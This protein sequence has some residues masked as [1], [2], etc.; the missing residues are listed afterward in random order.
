[1]NKYSQLA[2]HCC[3]LFSC[4]TKIAEIIES[5]REREALISQMEQVGGGSANRNGLT[6][7]QVVR[8]SGI[9]A[10]LVLEWQ[11]MLPWN[12]VFIWKGMSI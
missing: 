4:R 11:A 12:T 1:M 2:S 3:S 9:I 5:V 6:E 7:Q 10:E 8:L